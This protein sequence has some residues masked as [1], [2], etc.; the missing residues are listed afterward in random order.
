MQKPTPA[1]AADSRPDS[2]PDWEARIS[3]TEALA[4]DLGVRIAEDRALR[5]DEEIV[6]PETPDDFRPRAY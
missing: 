2:P 6:C 3:R 1:P 4:A 5:M